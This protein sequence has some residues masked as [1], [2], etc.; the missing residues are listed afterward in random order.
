MIYIYTAM[1]DPTTEDRFDAFTCIDEPTWK[2][3]QSIRQLIEDTNRSMKG[4]PPRRILHVAIDHDVVQIHESLT[5]IL[6]DTVCR[7][8]YL[9]HT[10]RPYCISSYRHP[11]LY[12]RYLHHS[13]DAT[14]TLREDCIEISARLRDPTYGYRIDTQS[15]DMPIERIE[16]LYEDICRKDHSYMEQRSGLLSLLTN[17]AIDLEHRLKTEHQHYEEILY[18]DL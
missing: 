4:R 5:E 6:P 16:S 12:E 7:H 11:D 8:H 10:F 17:R 15:A 13:T 3:I 14:L 1:I 2:E 9:N 18:R